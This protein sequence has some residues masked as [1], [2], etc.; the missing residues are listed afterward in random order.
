[1]RGW[2]MVGEHGERGYEKGRIASSVTGILD[3]CARLND[4]RRQ[5]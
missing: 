5:A 2:G 4:W 1:M 3:S